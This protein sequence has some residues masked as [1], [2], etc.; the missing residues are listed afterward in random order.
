M[1]IGDNRF[2]LS[3]L[4]LARIAGAQVVRQQG[5]LGIQRRFAL[6]QR[7]ALAPVGPI[8]FGQGVMFLREVGQHAVAMC[9]GQRLAAQ[10]TGGRIRGPEHLN[11]LVQPLP[12]GLDA[13]VLGPQRGG[14]LTDLAQLGGDRIAPDLLLG[15]VRQDPL[16][17]RQRLGLLLPGRNPATELGLAVGQPAILGLQRQPGLIHSQPRPVDPFARLGVAEQAGVPLSIFGARRA[18]RGPAGLDLRSLRQHRVELRQPHFGCVEL[19]AAIDQVALRAGQAAAQIGK[20]ARLRTA[21][22]HRE[23]R[24]GLFDFGCAECGGALG[25]RGA[26]SLAVAP[27]NRIVARV[28]RRCL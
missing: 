2:R 3:G 8:A 27:R 1:T 9:A 7:F 5:V 23:P 14:S 11:L 19:A 4:A 20:L 16:R 22:L 12:V 28:Q 13:I 24:F 25:G 26:G 18:E 6:G 21:L 15:H 10:G 17:R